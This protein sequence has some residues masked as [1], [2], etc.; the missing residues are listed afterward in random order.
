[1]P[2]RAQ[3]TEARCGPPISDTGS[4]LVLIHKVCLD[5]F[6]IR[7]VKISTEQVYDEKTVACWGNATN[8]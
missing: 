4:Y 3:G 6:F 2:T 5:H 7:S 8:T 1:M